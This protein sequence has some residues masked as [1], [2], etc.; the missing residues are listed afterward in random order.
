MA[1]RCPA[2]TT[3]Y[4]IKSGD[5]LYNIARRNNTTVRA[6]MR[7]NPDINPRNLRV[8]SMICIP[9]LRH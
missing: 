5:T 3:P 7:V 6:I 9:T 4:Y 2:D 8:G 1:R